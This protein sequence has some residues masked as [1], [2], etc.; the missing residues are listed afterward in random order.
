MRDT[1]LLHKNDKTTTKQTIDKPDLRPTKNLPR[2]KMVIPCPNPHAVEYKPLD[3]NKYPYNK[4]TKAK[5]ESLAQKAAGYSIPF[6]DQVYPHPFVPTKELIWNLAG[7]GRSIIK[8]NWQELIAF[9]PHS[10]DPR[11]CELFEKAPVALMDWLRGIDFTDKGKSLQIHLPV[12]QKEGDH[13]F[14]NLFTIILKGTKP[15]FIKFLLEQCVIPLATKGAMFYAHSL[16]PSNLSWVVTNFKA[17]CNCRITNE[18]ARLKEVLAWILE[19]LY[20]C[21]AL[22][23]IAHFIQQNHPLDTEI[24]KLTPAKIIYKATR[25]YHIVY[26][27]DGNQSG[28]AEPQYQ[29]QGEPVSLDPE[30]QRAW[31]NAVCQLK[32]KIG[33]KELLV[34]KCVIQKAAKKEEPKTGAP[35][36]FTLISAPAQS[37]QRGGGRGKAPSQRGRGRGGRGGRGRG[38]SQPSNYQAY[39]YQ[40]PSFNSQQQLPYP[41]PFNQGGWVFDP[42]MPGWS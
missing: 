29:L 42:N 35:D 22:Q 38:R 15:A 33:Y 12:P 9:V 23:T 1:A 30:E 4:Q 24:T 34:D 13:T 18:P 27:E 16:S 14:S 7:F 36:G 11:W 26:I 32:F 17:G 8:E 6:T 3:D 40:Y 41:P 31:L 37:N 2:N 28:E 10:G 5:M 20:D 19:K 21:K 39:P 25:S